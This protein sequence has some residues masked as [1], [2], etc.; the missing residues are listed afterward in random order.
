M[1]DRGEL[2]AMEDDEKMDA[3]KREP[4]NDDD[5]DEQEEEHQRARAI[6]SPQL[7]S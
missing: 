5:E 2:H 7:P 6:A 3:E 4:D 1:W